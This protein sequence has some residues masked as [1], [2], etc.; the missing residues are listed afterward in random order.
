MKFIIKCNRDIEGDVQYRLY[1]YDNKYKLFNGFLSLSIDKTWLK[2]R[3]NNVDNC[4]NY[5][6]ESA[7]KYTKD[8]LASMSE[9]VIFDGGEE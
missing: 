3:N 1:R 9:D 8:R 6:K 4:I 2:H 5:L 7:I